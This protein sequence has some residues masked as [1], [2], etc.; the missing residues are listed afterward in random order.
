MMS[1]AYYARL[2]PKRPAAFSRFVVTKML[3]GDLGFDGVVISDDLANAQ[4]VARFS[5]GARAVRFI[6][7]G[8]DLVLSVDPAPVPEMYAAVLRRART[9]ARFQ[10]LV[11][12][13]ALRVL[14]AKQARGLL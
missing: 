6:R 9:N 5:P 10:D 14:R 4:Q 7:A 11:D 12:A 3:R 13:A 2:D 8:G 1:T